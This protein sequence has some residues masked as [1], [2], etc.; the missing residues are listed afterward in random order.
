MKTV[1]IVA[2]AFCEALNARGHKVNTKLVVNAALIHDV[3]RICDFKDMNFNYFDQRVTLKDLQIWEEI[4]RKYGKIGHTKALTQILK[5]EGY[6]DLA[7]LVSKHGFHSVS[8]LK[9][10]DEK[11]LFYADKRAEG[12]K[13]VPLKTR[14][15]QG[16]KKHG[17]T[18]K[19][20]VS[21]QKIQ[22]KIIK[23][24]SE[25]KK[26]LGGKLAM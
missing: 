12:A 10:L 9:T 11:V 3:L 16:N 6:A 17:H 1:G 21:I 18:F 19:P 2:K 4:R 15:A 24:E 13:L 22:Q 7:R 14:F 5:K 23:L 20:P 25:L 8:S 26:L